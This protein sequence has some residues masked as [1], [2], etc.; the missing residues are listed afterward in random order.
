MPMVVP[1]LLQILLALALVYVAPPFAAGGLSFWLTRSLRGWKFSTAT[2][3]CGLAVSLLL[4]VYVLFEFSTHS[5]HKS[6][7]E[8]NADVARKYI[9]DIY[10]A[11]ESTFLCLG[12]A[13]VGAF[14]R[15]RARSSR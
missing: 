12:G 2:I 11:F 6:I 1:P 14:L 9:V 5:V 8:T 15:R 13:I 10:W 7:D 4:L 3:A